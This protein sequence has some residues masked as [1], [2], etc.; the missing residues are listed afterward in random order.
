[1]P[2]SSVWWRKEF[3]LLTLNS[4]FQMI[5]LNLRWFFN[6]G[7][8]YFHEPGGSTAFINEAGSRT[9]QKRFLLFFDRYFYLPCSFWM[10]FVIIFFQTLCESHGCMNRGVPPL[11][12]PKRLVYCW[13]DL[14]L[15]FD[16]WVISLCQFRISFTLLLYDAIGE[17]VTEKS[18]PF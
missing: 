6:I 2:F 17:N 18:T 4:M 5:G 1:M 14:L 16:S 8:T 3:S 9:C 10:F 7:V 13:K 15:T 11:M 12:Y